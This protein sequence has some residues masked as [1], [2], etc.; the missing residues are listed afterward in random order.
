MRTKGSGTQWISWALGASAAVL[1]PWMVLLSYTLPDQ[2]RVRNWAT[3]WVGLD[4][5]LTLGCLATA[6][7]ARRSDERAR[8]AAAA[9]AAVAGLDCWF[10]VTTASAGAEFAQ[11]LGSAAAELLLAA[12]CGYLA[13]RPR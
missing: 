6:L 11:A 7:L 5:L 4:V 13:L 3:A 1:I 10:D 9:T 12:V 2:K 8:I